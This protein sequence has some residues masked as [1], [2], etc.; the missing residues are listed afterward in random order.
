MEVLEAVAAASH[1]TALA[2]RGLR[3][4]AELAKDRPHGDRLRYMAGCR[5]D[6]CRRANTDYERARVA[7]RKAGD[8]NGVVDVG[9]ARAHLAKLSAQGVGRRTVGD[10]S[11]I[12]DT[13]LSAVISGRQ[14]GIRA[15]TERAILA[16]TR[17]AAADHALTSADET[18]RMLDELAADGYTKT[19]L[20][21]NL[22]YK[23]HALQF[24]RQRVT[25]RSAY[26]VCRLYE[27]LKLTDARKTLAL[28]DE[29]RDEG[30]R[31]DQPRV[32][33]LRPRT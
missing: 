8:W 23:R 26:A 9:R 10:V 6:G 18:W 13:V 30:F 27:R 31:I 4:V 33:A 19:E 14:V 16:V 3:P 22:G 17:D 1:T 15:R 24:K 12:A 2:K 32:W 20:A 11:G 25:V 28:L 21:R 7:A 5:C 29:L